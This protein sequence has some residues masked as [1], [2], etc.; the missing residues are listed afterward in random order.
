MDTG[1]RVGLVVVVLAGVMLAG[2]AGDWV[3]YT[4]SASEWSDGAQATIE[5]VDVARIGT[6]AALDV[7]ER[8]IHLDATA[9]AAV[10]AVTVEAFRA[11]AEVDRQA[12]TRQAA[13]ATSAAWD[14]QARETAAANDRHLQATEAARSA[15]AQAVA[16]ANATADARNVAET[17]EARR[18]EETRQAVAIEGTRARQTWEQDATATAWAWGYEATAQAEYATRQAQATSDV[19]N[20]TRQS[21]AATATRHTQKREQTM[22]EVRDYGLPA[23]GLVLILAAIIG[24]VWVVKQWVSRPQ[25]VERSILGDAKP[26]M[27]KGKD[28][29]YVLVDLDRQP[30]AALK[31]SPGGDVSAPQLRSAAM[32]ERITRNDQAVDAMTRPRLGGGHSTGPALPLAEPPASKPEGL[33]G[34]RV[35]RTL[36]QASTAG[37]L[38]PGQVEA[39]EATWAESEED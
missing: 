24:G 28:G 27:F 19:V 13:A 15:T 2:C 8:Q 10:V 4:P 22:D 31:L 35:L 11:R 38:P 17:T 7:A 12:A 6:L 9:Q 34:V 14:R 37:L 25:I 36:R 39:I 5:G 26:L 3:T 1:K 21:H 18:I 33:T 29:S 20:A 23:F 16:N 30:S 32:E